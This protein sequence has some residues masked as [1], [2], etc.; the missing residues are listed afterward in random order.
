M[1]NACGIDGGSMATIRNL[2][3][4]LLFLFCKHDL[5]EKL[6]RVT[7][8]QFSSVQFSSVQFSSIRFSSVMICLKMLHCFPRSCDYKAITFITE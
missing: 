7:S 2:C 3:C 6:L 1:L 5:L 8:V 4:G